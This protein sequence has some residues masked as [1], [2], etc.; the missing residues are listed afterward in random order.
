MTTNELQIIMFN[1]GTLINYTYL[2]PHF[3]L[4]FLYEIE[5][6]WLLSLVFFLG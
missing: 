6:G 5:T 4:D 2:Y 1:Y 3:L